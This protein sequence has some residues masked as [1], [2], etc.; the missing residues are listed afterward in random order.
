[1]KKLPIGISTFSEIVN[2][3][4][5]YIDKTK[6][7]FELINQYKYSFLSR[8]RR[9]G[10]SLFLDT[11]YEIFKGNKSLFKD[12]YIYDKW[13]FEEYPIINVSFSGDLRS[14]E[15]L[16]ETIFAILR[17]NQKNL[18]IECEDAN[19]FSLCFV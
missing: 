5:L 17:N 7:A 12:L 6:S 13:N 3:N 19:N 16:R 4:Y 10:K 18:K 1:M 14:G 2:N 15:R 11:L 9:F 8:P